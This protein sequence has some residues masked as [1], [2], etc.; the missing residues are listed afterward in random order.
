MNNNWQYRAYKADKNGKSISEI[1]EGEMCA[2]S[3]THLAVLLRQSGLQVLDAVKLDPNHSVATRRL[4]KMKAR[5]A[6][7]EIE[8]HPIT[9]PAIH[10]WFSWLIPPFLKR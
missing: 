1:V 8:P 9:K 7:P 3:F 6:P 4:A 5:I 2:N 10:R